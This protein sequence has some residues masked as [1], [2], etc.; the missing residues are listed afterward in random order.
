MA[1]GS[2]MRRFSGLWIDR[3][4]R[5]EPEGRPGG[6]GRGKRVRGDLPLAVLKSPGPP[7]L[8]SGSCLG[9]LELPPGKYF[10]GDAGRGPG[11]LEAS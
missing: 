2:K 7:G 4:P 6:P 5:E 3:E 9:S 1:T 10:Q 11:V 8:A